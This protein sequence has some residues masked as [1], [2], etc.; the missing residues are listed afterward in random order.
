MTY[1]EL[2]KWFRSKDINKQ[3]QLLE[4]FATQRPNEWQDFLNNYREVYE[5]TPTNF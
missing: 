4:A 5:L 2:Y 3:V 1:E